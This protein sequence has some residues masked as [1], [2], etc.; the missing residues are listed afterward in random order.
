MASFCQAQ[1][2]E[3]RK[4][5]QKKDCA[6]SHFVP[7]PAGKDKI[8]GVNSEQV[9]KWENGSCKDGNKGTHIISAA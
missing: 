5:C 9:D 4:C 6:G 7:F 1:A 3:R 8:G 2:D